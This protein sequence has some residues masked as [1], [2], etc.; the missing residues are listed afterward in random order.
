MVHGDGWLM[1]AFGYMSACRR[2]RFCHEA[3]LSQMK[4][5]G[6]QPIRICCQSEALTRKGYFEY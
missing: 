5:R 6:H 3:I 1:R 2:P 4:A